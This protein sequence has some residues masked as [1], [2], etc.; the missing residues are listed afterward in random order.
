MQQSG[1]VKWFNQAKAYGFVA[2]DS[3]DDAFLH[4]NDVLGYEPG[5]LQEGDRVECEV[6]NAPR[7]PRAVNARMV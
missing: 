6:V 5:A 7:G 3:G 1:T 2:L 4:A